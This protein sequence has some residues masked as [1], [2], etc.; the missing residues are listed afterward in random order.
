MPVEISRACWHFFFFLP[1]KTYMD[2]LIEWWGV[3][4]KIGIGEISARS[5]VMFLF[6]VALLRLS[7][8]RPFGKGDA[9]DTVMTI[10]LGA[11]A[12]R[13]IVGAT[14]FFS[15]IAS[16]IVMI[17]IHK[18]LSKLTFYNKFIGRKLKGKAH[19]LYSDGNFIEQNLQ[20]ANITQH[21]IHEELRLSLQQDS[22]N[23]IDKVFMER[24]GEISF[25]K[26]EE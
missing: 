13:G 20:E 7:G 1:G 9:F 22:M 2:F 19:V 3:K 26:K 8:M 11:V 24:T 5:I 21:D 14:P 23:K 4:D 18:L 12:A 25:V 15:T 10:L 6:L 17:I 16:D